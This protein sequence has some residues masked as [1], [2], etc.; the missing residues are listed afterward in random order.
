MT[1][2]CNVLSLSILA[3]ALC[4]PDGY[5]PERLRALLRDGSD[6]VSSFIEAILSSDEDQMQKKLALLADYLSGKNSSA[7]WL[8]LG[9]L[10]ASLFFR[11]AA[12]EYFEKGAR[13][14]QAQGD[15][16]GQSQAWNSI[17]SLYGDD[18]DW[19]RAGWFYEKALQALEGGKSQYL[20][21]PILVN[22]GRVNRLQGDFCKA[23]QCYSR[24]LNLQD[25]DD[26]LDRADAL[27]CL[28]ELCQIRG[29]LTGAEEC[30]QK[31]LSEQGKA[32]DQGG[33]A[34]SLAALA[35]VYQ[36]TGA[37][38]RV[39]SCLEKARHHLQDIGDEMGAARMHS[40]LA[41][42]FFLEGRH[43]EAVG[44]YEKSL[45]TLEECD[46]LLAARA[47]SRIGQCFL[48]LGEDARA[49]Y[50]LKRAREIM[51]SQGDLCSEADLLITLAGSYRRQDRLEE[52][53]QCTQQCLKVR[54]QQNDPHAIAAAY[55][56]MGLIYADRREYNQGKVCFQKAADLFT[57]TGICIFAA[58]AFSNLGSMCHLQGELEDALIYYRR[59]LEIFSTLDNRQGRS[60]TEANL[61]L[62]YQSKG[63]LSLAEDYLQK[64]LATRD[65]QADVAG[66]ASIRLSLGLTAQLKGDWDYAQEYFEQAAQAFD[67]SGGLARFLS[68]AKQSWK[69]SLG[70]RRHLQGHFMLQL[71]SGC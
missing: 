39:E 18:E 5:E 36:L 12:E 70:S 1:D 22:L 43:K 28:G 6:L 17:G 25:A 13:L 15:D 68:G 44:H 45:S 31:S 54:E 11:R 50:H 26:R 40:Q 30:Y 55:S 64:S 19:D 10:A 42:F 32:R 63:E 61:G 53:L 71:E 52:A 58:E 8:D 37:A 16:K 41:D 23:E 27:Y 2:D 35:S 7:A 48:D 56:C 33:M 51:Q 69:P 24:A 59:A 21:R 57:Q 34:A 47:Q 20:M 67:E 66:G 46:N 4:Q 38:T 60:Q 62:I 65:E 49:E 9:R 29:D 3:D 14:A